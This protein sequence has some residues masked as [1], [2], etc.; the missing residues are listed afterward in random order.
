MEW[1]PAPAEVAEAI[2]IDGMWPREQELCFFVNKVW[3]PCMSSGKDGAGYIDLNMSMMRLLTGC[4]D[5]DFE[6]K[7][8]EKFPLKKS[9]WKGSPMTLVGSMKL[10][11][12]YFNSACNRFVVR[13]AEP[14][15][16][17][18]GIG[19]HESFCRTNFFKVPDDMDDGKRAEMTEVQY[20]ELIA[21]MCG[22][23]W[24]G[25]TYSA[26]QTALVAT[27]GHFF[28]KIGRSSRAPA[29]PAPADDD[30]D[31]ARESYLEQA[32]TVT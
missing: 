15:E 28:S 2:R 23:A 31:E 21:N 9:P 30:S 6:G 5:Y 12:R 16:Y 32:A 7:P 19:W 17:L 29:A 3:P 10:A 1:P 8:D 26:V 22:N 27:S 24:S 14:I 25:F 4:I 11:V 13:L 18:R 20:G